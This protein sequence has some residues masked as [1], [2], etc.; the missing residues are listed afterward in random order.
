MICY[1]IGV[2]E[3]KYHSLAVNTVRDMWHCKI[4]NLQFLSNNI[5]VKFC[6]EVLIP[7]CCSL[8]NEFP[9]LKCT[10]KQ[11]VRQGSL[12][13]N[14]PHQRNASLSVGPSSFLPPLH[15]NPLAL[16]HRDLELIHNISFIVVY[17]INCTHGNSRKSLNLKNYYDILHTTQV[18]LCN[19]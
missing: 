17:Y 16:F 8:I 12:G 9:H 15:P 10:P 6:Q 3:R 14:F 13:V 2:Q 5:I 1:S 7:V 4:S 19:E 18:K 11:E